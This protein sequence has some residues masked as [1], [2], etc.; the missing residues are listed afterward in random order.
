MKKKI[1]LTVLFFLLVFF[2]K[3]LIGTDKEYLLPSEKVISNFVEGIRYESGNWDHPDYSKP[4]KSLGNHR[5][6]IKIKPSN[7]IVKATIPWRRGDDKPEKKGVVIVNAKSGKRVKNVF[8]R[9]INSVLGSLLFEP[10]KKSDTYYVYYLPHKSTGGYYPKVDYLPQ[11]DAEDQKWL[12]KC[13]NL[14]VLQYKSLPSAKVIVAQSIDDFHSFF[15]MEI[16]ATKNEINEFMKNN[17]MKYYLFPEYRDNPIRMRKHL[18][19]HWMKRG[20]K[21]GVKDDVKRGEFYTFQIGLY[22]PHKPL[23]DVKISFSGLKSNFGYLI[24]VTGLECFNT[25]GIGLDGKFFKKKLGVK[26]GEVKSLWFGLDIPVDVKKGEYRGTFSIKP[27]GMES[28]SIEVVLNILPEIIVNKGDNNPKNMSRLRWLN[29]QA[30]TDKNFIVKPF[31]PVEIN[32]KTLRILGREILLGENGLPQEILSFFSEEMTYL[33]SKPEKIIAKPIKF[34]ILTKKRKQEVWESTPFSVDQSNK[35]EASWTV[36]NNSTNFI[37]KINGRL[38]YDG[39]LNYKIKLTAKKDV[40]I[41]DISLIVPIDKGT[42]QYIVGLGRKGGKRHE[43]IAWKWDREFHQ[44][45]VWIGSVNRGLQYVLRDENYERPLN[46]NFYHNKP[47]NLPPSWYNGGKGGIRIRENKGL[48]IAENY[49]G[50]REVKKGETL[51]FNVRFLITPFKLIDTK[52][53]FS[54]RFVHKYEPIDSVI[55]SGGSVVNVHHANEINPYINYPFFNIEKQKAYIDEAHSK[56]VKVKLYNTIRELSYKAYEIFPLKSLGDEIFNDGKGGG[57]SWLQE[58]LRSNYHSAWHATSVN[59]AAI[60]NKGTSRWTNYYIEGLRWLAKNQ[61]I[62]GLY[63]DDIAFSRETVK[64]IITVLNKNRDEIIIDL[65]SANQFNNR[66]GFINSI[67][68]YMEHLPYISRLWFGEYFEYDMNP[69]YWLTEVSGIPFGLTGEMLEKGG[70]PFRGMVYGMTTRIYGKYNP[71]ELWKLFDD[72]DI[73]NSRMIGYWVK[74]APIKTSNRGIRS[75]IYLHKDRIMIAIGSW[76]P[77]NEDVTLKIDWKKIKFSK[78]K[79]V[80]I[81]PKIIGLQ[82]FKEFTVGK[83]ITVKGNKG[84]IL[85]LKNGKY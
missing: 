49:S 61:K 15:P 78:D 69:D 58:H 37:I 55:K 76:S 40:D 7:S 80:L 5:F 11:S 17:P 14:S 59:D 83:P 3:I 41:S 25:S 52:K 28:K 70:H 16:I 6:I 2:S 65:H 45:G 10:D 33:K 19:L 44:E 21:K 26:A 13:R 79:A 43:N 39:M 12:K 53:H 71:G 35:G 42:A 30:G 8:V 46:T 73:S 51:N 4:F 77:E 48:V 74:N 75:T 29:S 64:R 67:F 20:L 34:N 60:L 84:I 85:I 18:P 31:L 62:D 63:L 56:G 27:H 72:F 57:H 24:P 22:S 68:L 82:E 23:T 66:D 50:V 54:T 9:E 36:D 32:G 47:L 81:S 38:E 1:N